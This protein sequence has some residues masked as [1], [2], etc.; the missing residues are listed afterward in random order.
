MVPRAVLMKFGLVLVDTARQVNAAHSKTTVIA[1][2]TKVNNVKEKNV[3]VARPKAVVN[4]V[5]PKAV[6]NAARPK[7]VVNVVQ[8]NNVNVVK[9]LQLW[10]KDIQGKDQQKGSKNKTNPCTER[11][12]AKPKRVSSREPEAIKGILVDGKW[13]DNPD[14][15]K[16]EFYNH[17]AKRFSVPNWSY[18]PIEGIFPR[19]MGADS[20]H[21]LEDDISDDEIKKPLVGEDV[22]NAVKEFIN[23][24]IRYE[25]ISHEQIAF[26]K[27]RHILDEPFILNEIVSWCKSRKEQALLFKVDFQKAFNSRAIDRGR[28]IPESPW[29]SPIPIGYGD[30]D[31]NRFPDRDGDGDGDEDGSLPTYYM[32][33]FKATDGVL[34]HLERLRNSFFLGAKMDERKLTWICWR[35]LWRISNM[36]G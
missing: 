14:R 21:D 20:S 35:K 24:S 28:K 13:I 33:L 36:A 18:F 8:G 34:S 7:V 22:S 29:G 9:D 10:K 17:F 32:P 27:G 19:S 25:L 6:V 4:A 30:G 16:R 23:S 5:R 1:A 26:I 3:N 12:R 31:V 2:R 15:V 11:K